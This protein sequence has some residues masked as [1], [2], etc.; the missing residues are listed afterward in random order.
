MRRRFPTEYQR[1]WWEL[2]TLY[3]SKKGHRERKKILPRNPPPETRRLRCVVETEFFRQ[4]TNRRKHNQL[5]REWT[6]M[7]SSVLWTNANLSQTMNQVPIPSSSLYPGPMATD[8]TRALWAKLKRWYLP[9][10]GFLS[11]SLIFPSIPTQR[12]RHAKIFPWLQN[13]FCPN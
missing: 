4:K 8:P 12:E 11:L 13:T 9:Y 3:K 7:L 5:D 6:D 10:A 2:Y 1:R